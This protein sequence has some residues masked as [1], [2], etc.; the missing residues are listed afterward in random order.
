MR[1]KGGE[2]REREEGGRGRE[3]VER[4]EEQRSR[5]GRCCGV[6]RKQKLN[7]SKLRIKNDQRTSLLSIE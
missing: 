6:L 5:S 3:K 2:E 1:G 7:L 4:R